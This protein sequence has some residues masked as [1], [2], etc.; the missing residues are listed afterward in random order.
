MPVTMRW[1]HLKRGF[2]L[3]ELLVVIAIIAVLIGLLLPAVQKVREAAARIQCQNN[4]KQIG[5][6]LHNF[7]DT[8][9]MFPNGGGDW[10]TSVSYNSGLSQFG[11]AQQT[12]GYHYQLLPYIEQA[13]LYAL[14]DYLVNANGT[15]NWSIADNMGGKGVWPAG[16]YVVKL[17]NAAGN[18]NTRGALSKGGPTKTFLCPSRRSAAQTSWSTTNH[19]DYAAAVP[20][21]VPLPLN[22][23]GQITIEL[24]NAE[25]GIGGYNGVIAKGVDWNDGNKSGTP[26]P[27]IN[28][29]SVVDGTSN[30]FVIADKFIPT[31]Y[32]ANSGSWFGSDKGAFLGLDEIN[33]RTTATVQVNSADAKAPPIPNPQRDYQVPGDT[34]DWNQPMWQ[35][36]FIFGSAHPSGIN[37]VFADGSVRAI[38]YTI[39][40]QLFNALGHRSDGTVLDLSQL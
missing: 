30:T 29:A 6:A 31:Q 15:P 5:L 13:N 36:G 8:N 25:W 2:T 38:S 22:K 16:S 21:P 4:L 18:T 10:D 34:N 27:R 3:I 9:L 40:P 19:S 11:A 23:A 32:Y 35:T 12:A 17:E 39:N 7:H 28:V 33:H 37:C 1:F 14:P 26:G 20:G 24:G